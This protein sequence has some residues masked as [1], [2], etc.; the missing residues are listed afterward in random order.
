MRP[1]EDA[2]AFEWSTRWARLARSIPHFPRRNDM[3]RF[4]ASLVHLARVPI[5]VVLL[6]LLVSGCGLNTIPSLEESAKA[7]W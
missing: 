6:G 7:K 2:E 1:T 4:T 5:V 3:S